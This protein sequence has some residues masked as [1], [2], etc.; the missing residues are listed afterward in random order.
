MS[1]YIRGPVCG[2]DNCRSRLWRIIDGRRTC[3]YGHVMEGDVEFNNE[4]DDALSGV[5]TR[6][7]NLTTNATGNF[8]SSLNF[9]QSQGPSQ[10]HEDDK[11][12][13]G[14]EG[15]R[16]F[17]KCFQ[18]IL[19]E[20]CKWLMEQHDFPPEYKDTVK[21]LWLF[22]LK[23][24][25]PASD[26]EA[27]NIPDLQQLNLSMAASI[28]LLYLA[29]IHLR[30]PALPSDFIRWSCSMKLPYFRSSHL[31]PTQWRKQ[32]PSYYLQIL[33]GGPLPVSSQIYR[34]TASVA[35]KVGFSRNFRN[36]ISVDLLL[37]RLLLLTALPPEFFIYT[38]TLVTL[39]DNPGNFSVPETV[40][41]HPPAL[42]NVPEVRIIAYYILSTS[43]V[44]RQPTCI[45]FIRA[46]LNHNP[47][48]FSIH[49]LSAHRQPSHILSLK[50][51]DITSYLDWFQ[52]SLLP[53]YADTLTSSL[54]QQIYKRKLYAVAPLNPRNPA[55]TPAP[56]L[57]TSFTDSLQETFINVA[58]D[59]NESR[60]TKTRESDAHMSD[61]VH[62]R[63]IQLVSTEFALHSNDLND[64]VMALRRHCLRVL[65][66][67][68]DV[69]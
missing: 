18:H 4:D 50:S 29:C 41:S 6:R 64:A 1:T 10:I 35:L 47:Q 25:S 17:L 61:A 12:L 2:T 39:V 62:T 57:P 42:H 9:S 51:R 26:A 53:R 36:Q 34:K 30:I 56:Q 3:Q 20:Q 15:K 13:F 48:N 58:Q 11:K 67:K 45:P 40:P 59:L 28:S 55:P 22:Y 66:A 68:R 7:L 32:L 27:D 52:E 60:D 16:L 43:W 5:I 38:K 24:L 19:K 23:S 21:L 49:S 69:I 46:W 14:V 65:R 31:L 33:D 63:L 44:L 54:D 37:L 8:Q